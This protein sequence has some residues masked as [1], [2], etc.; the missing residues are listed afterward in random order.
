MLCSCFSCSSIFCAFFPSLYLDLWGLL[1]KIRQ[2]NLCHVCST[3]FH[4]KY[5]VF[6]FTIKKSGNSSC[7]AKTRIFW[8]LFVCLFWRKDYSFSH[9]YLS[10]CLFRKLYFLWNLCFNFCIHSCYLILCS[11]KKPNKQQTTNQQQWTT[12]VLVSIRIYVF[13]QY[14]VNLD[15]C[16]HI[17]GVLAQQQ[18]VC[19]LLAGKPMQ[20]LI[21]LAQVM[22]DLKRQSCRFQHNWATEIC[23][24]Y[25]QSLLKSLPK[26]LHYILIS[27]YHLS[28]KFCTFYFEQNE[29]IDSWRV[30]SVHCEN[31]WLLFWPPLLNVSSGLTHT[32]LANGW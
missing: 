3:P 22:K 6:N 4:W 28:S 11:I 25:M 24:L 9:H 10:F 14:T 8:G 2:N 12:S 31:Q 15:R 26:H 5:S 7:L 19:L 21:W 32:R 23:A 18:K 16:V 13:R 27:C 29:Q 30:P 1:D 17:L 20:A